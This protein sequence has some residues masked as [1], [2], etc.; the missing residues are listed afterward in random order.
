MEND[1]EQSS[2]KHLL[3]N[4]NLLICI[5]LVYYYEMNCHI[6]FC[7][8]KRIISYIW[9]LN[10]NKIKHDIEI[11]FQFYF[12]IKYNLYV[13]KCILFKSLYL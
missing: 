10:V 11:N 7:V 4:L 1:S 8:S 3:I 5:N 9:T 13:V 6:I 12:V 2:V